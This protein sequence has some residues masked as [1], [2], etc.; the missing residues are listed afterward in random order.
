MDKVKE[1]PLHITYPFTRDVAHTKCR[2][3]GRDHE[4]ENVEGMLKSTTPSTRNN[5]SQPAFTI[6]PI[7]DI[8]YFIFL[9]QHRLK[10]QTNKWSSKAK[11]STVLEV[12]LSL[13]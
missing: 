13:F 12:H 1:T 8:T 11:G 9:S 10:G 5:Q 7:D 4:R 6:Y 3:H 2:D